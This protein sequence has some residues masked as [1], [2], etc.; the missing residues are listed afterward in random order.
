ML[1]G[2]CQRHVGYVNKYYE[3]LDLCCDMINLG[4]AMLMK[5]VTDNNDDR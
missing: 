5:I 4:L 3:R 1:S 2:F